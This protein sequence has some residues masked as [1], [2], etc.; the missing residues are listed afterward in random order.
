MKHAESIYNNFIVDAPRLELWI[1]QKLCTDNPGST[2]FRI[3]EEVSVEKA[4]R[5][6]DRATQGW[7]ADCFAEGKET[8]ATGHDEHLTDGGKQ[9]VKIETS[10]P[11]LTTVKPFRV[12]YV[13]SC[14][15]DKNWHVVKEILLT[16]KYDAASD[17]IVSKNWEVME[18][19]WTYV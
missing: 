9:V 17:A 7:L 10:H 19:D 8:Y 6:V 16:L 11:S 4:L 1:D 14:A 3:M 2:F 15:S 12:V 18:P 13:P 5:L